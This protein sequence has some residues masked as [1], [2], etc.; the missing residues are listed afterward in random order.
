MIKG[1]KQRSPIARRLREMREKRNL[2]QRGLGI[3]AGIDELSAS[4][5]VNQYEMNKRVPDYQTIRQLADVLEIT[6]AYFYTD[7]NDLAELIALFHSLSKRKRL[8]LRKA[9]REFEE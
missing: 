6:P 9:I 7:D 8:A 4:A 1:I 3:L 5:R 2:S